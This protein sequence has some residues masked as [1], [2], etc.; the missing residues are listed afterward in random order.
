MSNLFDALQRSENEQAGSDSPRAAK[1]TELLQRAERRTV[2]NWEAAFSDVKPETASISDNGEIVGGASTPHAGALA[3][4]LGNPEVRSVAEHSDILSQFQS[5]SISPTSQSRIV[6]LTDRENPT[7]EAIR[8]LGVRLRDLRRTRPLKKVLITSTIPRKARVRSLPTLPVLLRTRT[9]K[10]Y[11]WSKAI[12]AAHLSQR[13]LASKQQV[14][15][16]N[17]FGR[18]VTCVP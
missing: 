15:S 8:L 3:V 17:G 11:C 14:A 6:C 12:Y 5:L 1:A 10:K 13:C 7:A 2:L 16:L 9:T 18:N 4:A